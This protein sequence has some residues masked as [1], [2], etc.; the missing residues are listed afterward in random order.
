MEAQCIL[1]VDNHHAKGRD[2]MW[3]NMMLKVGS[4]GN[5]QFEFWM[6]TVQMLAGTP[7]IPNGVVCGLPHSLHTDNSI[8]PYIRS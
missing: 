8:V 6:F 1:Q 7:T 4:S 2:N 5:T 3:C